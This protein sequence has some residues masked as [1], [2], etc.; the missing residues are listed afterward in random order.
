VKSRA[1]K[2]IK[3]MTEELLELYS[4]RQKEEGR[5]FAADSAFEMDFERS[6]QYEETP[7]QAKAITKI[8]KEMEAGKLIDRLVCGDVGYGK[9]EVALRAAL[10][11]ALSGLQV[12]V[13]TPTTVLA[14]Q[15]FRNFTN[16]F[17]PYP[18]V[19]EMLA[20]LNPLRQAPL[21]L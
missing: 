15:H 5:L 18:I 4:A 9:T 7:D 20:C 8:K 11:T 1:K 21:M 16:R 17:K 13:L 2:S 10:K 3:D 19:V 12:A 14:D 6:F